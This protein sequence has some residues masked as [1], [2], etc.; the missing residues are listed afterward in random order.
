MALRPAGGCQGENVCEWSTNESLYEKLT[1]GLVQ[2]V[3][4][5]VALFCKRWG[6][7]ALQIC[8][9]QLES[10]KAFTPGLPCPVLVSPVQ[11][12]YSPVQGLQR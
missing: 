2:E 8:L 3:L 6:I 11:E 12:K 1:V 9:G 10:C 7:N 5:E 4:T